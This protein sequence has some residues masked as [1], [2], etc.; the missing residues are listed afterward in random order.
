MFKTQSDKYILWA[1]IGLFFFIFVFS[2]ANSKHLF[3]IKFCRWQ[4]LNRG[5]LV[6]EPTI[7]LT[8]LQ[9]LPKSGK[10]LMK[11]KIKLKRH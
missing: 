7:L 10:H 3:C 8:E 9:P 6:L 11:L 4:D 5:P 1:I 2:T